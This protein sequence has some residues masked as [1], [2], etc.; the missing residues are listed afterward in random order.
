MINCHNELGQ[1]KRS[2]G[3]FMGSGRDRMPDS[4]WNA[5]SM[6]AVWNYQLTGKTARTQPER[7]SGQLQ[8]MRNFEQPNAA[9]SGRH[10]HPVWGMFHPAERVSGQP[11]YMRNFKQPKQAERDS[12]YIFQTST[13]IKSIIYA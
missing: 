12:D 11:Q 9:T 5:L 3:G 2:L 10:G 6:Q 13:V 7:V 8:Y 4:M 1:E